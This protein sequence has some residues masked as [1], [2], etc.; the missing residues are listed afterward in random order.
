[1]GGEPC[2]KASCL[3]RGYEAQRAVL[4]FPTVHA[5]GEL[6]QLNKTKIILTQLPFG[7]S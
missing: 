6:F 7:G 3:C 2:S 5:E 4:A 1:M